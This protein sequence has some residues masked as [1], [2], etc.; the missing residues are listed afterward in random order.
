MVLSARREFDTGSH[1]L[2]KRREAFDERVISCSSEHLD[3]FRDNSIG[4]KTERKRRKEDA[5]ESSSLLVRR[6][7][8]KTHD[9]LL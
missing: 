1:R 5:S 9:P 4:G 6:R 2:K 3:E 8:E 7:R